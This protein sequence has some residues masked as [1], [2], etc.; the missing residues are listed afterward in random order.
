MRLKLSEK[1][2]NFVHYTKGML[3]NEL[4]NVRPASPL[5][6][7][8]QKKSRSLHSMLGVLQIG[9]VGVR[10]GSRLRPLGL[11]LGRQVRVVVA[12]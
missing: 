4:A 8:K 6:R 3:Q 2:P 11:G 12:F 1:R 7:P 10:L 5:T 9:L